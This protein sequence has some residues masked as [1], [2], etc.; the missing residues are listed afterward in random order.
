M[1]PVPPTQVPGAHI[2]LGGHQ[3]AQFDQKSLRWYMNVNLTQENGPELLPD[4][5]QAP[6]YKVN[7]IYK[8]FFLPLPLP[9][10]NA[11]SPQSTTQSSI[12]N[13]PGCTNQPAST[14]ASPVTAYSTH[15]P[16]P[17]PT[18]PSSIRLLS[19]TMALSAEV[20]VSLVFGVLMAII[21]LLAMVQAA[22]YAARACRGK[23]RPS[24][25]KHLLQ[26][27]LGLV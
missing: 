17:V 14:T 19:S 1:H 20:T 24:P 3:T 4:F 9:Q 6:H 23:N 8:Y 22:I 2:G 11:S 5:L 7:N 25:A 26:L 15:K 18:S 27:I 21:A 16:L 13:W 10:W 12:S